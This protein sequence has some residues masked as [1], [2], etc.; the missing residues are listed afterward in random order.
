MNNKLPDDI[1]FADL[2]YALRATSV[3]Q[4]KTIS[5][6]SKIVSLFLLI[7][8]GLITFLY[9]QLDVSE[10]AGLVL[11]GLLVSSTGL[12]VHCFLSLIYTPTEFFEDTQR[13]P[14]G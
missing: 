7:Q 12:L 9:Y 3:L 13:K 5:N 14:R 11:A 10:T 6:M 1:S 2:F 4:A 8:M